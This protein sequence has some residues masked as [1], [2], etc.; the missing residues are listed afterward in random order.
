[1]QL[2]KVIN[3]VCLTFMTYHLSGTQEGKS[4]EAVFDDR[5]VLVQPFRQEKC[6]HKKSII[7][8]I[9]RAAE[10]ILLSR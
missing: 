6:L 2:R 7:K 4:V 8:Y 10:I 3:C 1:M 9:S 5:E